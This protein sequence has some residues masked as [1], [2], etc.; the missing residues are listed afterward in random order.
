VALDDSPGHCFW[1][2]ERNLPEPERRIA[3]LA[4]RAER[5]GMGPIALRATGERRG[6][7]A[8][9]VLEGE[10]PALAGLVVRGSTV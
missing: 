9:V 10:P 4:R 5:L 2:L 8:R 7:L 1:V 6:E 3:T